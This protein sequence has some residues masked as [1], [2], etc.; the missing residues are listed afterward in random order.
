M[1]WPYRLGIGAIQHLAPLPPRIHQ[2]HTA[3]HLEVLR[4]GRLTD[5][6]RRPCRRRAVRR[7]RDTQDVSA[8]RS[9]IALKTSAVVAAR[10][11]EVIIFL[12]RN[13]SS[14]YVQQDPFCGEVSSQRRN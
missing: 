6:A 2:A 11:T 12:I 13:M 1:E 4:H 5:P 9:A 14:V 7:A 3:K 8:A 10:G